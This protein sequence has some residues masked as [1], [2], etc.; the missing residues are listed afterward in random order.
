MVQVWPGAGG[1]ESFTEALQSWSLQAGLPVVRADLAA[2]GSL[3][4]SQ[5]WFLDDSMQVD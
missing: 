1:P 4:I 3:N 2:D 5:H